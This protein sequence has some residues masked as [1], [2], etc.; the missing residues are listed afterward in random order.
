MVLFCDGASRGNPGPGA[1]GYV[2]WEDNQLVA[3]EGGRLGNVTNNVAEYEGLIRG[4]QKSLELGAKEITVKSDSELLV[5]QL[6]GLYRVRAPHLLPLFDK[7]KKA[8]G[9]FETVS[10]VHVSREKNKDADRMANLALNG[11]PA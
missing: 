11:R 9:C 7:A 1:F 5:R 2:I 3:E 6:S 4:L 8:L 10:I